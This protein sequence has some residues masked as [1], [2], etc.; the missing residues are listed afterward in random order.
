MTTLN[1]Q[2]GAS[3]ND[4]NQGIA[5]ATAVVLNGTTLLCGNKS[6]RS[7]TGIARFTNV[8]VPQGTTITSATLTMT[9]A[10]SYTG[11]TSLLNRVYCEAADNSAQ[12]TTGS[13]NLTSRTKTTA[14]TAW[15]NHITVA[16]TEYNIDITSAV[17]EVINRAGWVSGNALSAIIANDGSPSDEWQEYYAWDGSTTKA[18][19]LA[20]VYSTATKALPPFR[21]HNLA[22]KKRF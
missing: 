22:W 20:I 11:P 19:K 16:E 2:V 8:T 21:R 17:Q 10:D 6:T 14:N 18:P 1:L 3:A 4:A 7:L 12:P 9:G 15:D 5:S 13:N